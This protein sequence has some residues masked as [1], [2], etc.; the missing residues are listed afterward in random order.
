MFCS[1]CG[2]KA[3]TGNRFCGHC[4]APLLAPDVTSNRRPTAHIDTQADVAPA[5]QE[6]PPASAP[7]PEQQLQALKLELKRLKLQLGEANAQVAPV[8]APGQQAALQQ[9]IVRL[10]TQIRALESS[11]GLAP[12][13]HVD[14]HYRSETQ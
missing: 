14:E 11:R 4:G 9:H 6:E 8:G 2:A 5:D 3:Q 12:R 13:S 7:T 1:H 10:E